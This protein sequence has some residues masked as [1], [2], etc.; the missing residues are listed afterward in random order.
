M[1]IN[2]LHLQSNLTK[3]Q[4]TKSDT[5]YPMT[6]LQKAVCLVSQI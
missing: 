4:A 6:D 1:N 5:E 3:L 2:W